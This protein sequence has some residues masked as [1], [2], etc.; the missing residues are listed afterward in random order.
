MKPL[1]V[2][3]ALSLATV[4]NAQTPLTRQPVPVKAF[5]HI[6][7]G[8]IGFFRHERHQIYPDPAF[9]PETSMAL[10]PASAAGRRRKRLFGGLAGAGVGALL[11]AA[12]WSQEACNH[13]W[14]CV[15]KGSAI[16]GT[17]GAA[18]SWK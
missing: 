7:G 2:I 1:L 16:F 11:G 10:V 5:I 6:A 12:P 4:T 15:L 13:R 18:M 9:R 14:Q 17:V 3:T 8:L